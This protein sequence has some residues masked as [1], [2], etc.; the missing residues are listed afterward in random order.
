MKASVPLLCCA[1]LLFALGAAPASAAKQRVFVLTDIENEPD[2]AMSMV[3]FLVYANHWDVEGLVATTSIHQKNKVAPERIH[4]IVDA[5]GKVR[6]NLELHEPGFPAAESLRAAI[7]S[8]RPAYGMSA[9]GAGMDSPGSERLIAAADRDDPR[10]LWVTVWGGPNVLAQALWKVRATRSPELV[11]S[12]VAKL[13]V[14]T[15]SDQDDSGPW[16]RRNFPAL[17]YIASPGFHG[18]GAYHHAT[19]S[20]IS[21]DRFHGRFA[22]ADFPIVDNPWLDANIRSKGTLGTQYPQ[23]KFMMEGDSPSFLF[24]IDNGL[25]VPEH[26]DWGGWGGRYELYTP[27]MRK[28]FQAPETRPLW[29]DAED[30]VPGNDGNWHTSNK[31]TIW[32]WRQ[33][34]QNDFAARMD[35][36]VEPYAKANHPPVPRL[37]H[38]DRLAAKP[39]E[40]VMLSAAG[41]ADPDDD[42]LAYE[43]LYYPEAGSFAV[44]S[45][46]SGA[47]LA[48]EN[49]HAREAAFVVPTN[50]FA[51]G[52]LHLILAVRDS[53]T[54]SLT[55]YRRVIVSVAP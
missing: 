26:P 35:W 14:Y 37:A 51:P 15:I 24:L 43:W 1:A 29:T 47:P 52:T 32:R 54:P 5:Y 9:V 4:E 50:Y 53:G 23:V 49:E 48:I 16:I 33:A 39:G 13:R 40:R 45:G 7:V 20:G 36:T 19:W 55:R 8:G 42:A 17:F 3:R 31:A 34:F 30:E 21:G 41:S 25:G 2:D 12:F 18:G 28:W 44:Q 46:R 22:G 11:A 10:P 38:A 6:D 27:R